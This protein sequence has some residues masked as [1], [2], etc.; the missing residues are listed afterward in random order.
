MPNYE[1]VVNKIRDLIFV[2]S[3]NVIR[4]TTCSKFPIQIK[5][6]SESFYNLYYMRIIIF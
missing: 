6:N 2:V 3:D 1:K 4:Y 5:N